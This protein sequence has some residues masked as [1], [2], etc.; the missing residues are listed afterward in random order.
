MAVYQAAGELVELA[1][2][3]AADLL[4]ASVATS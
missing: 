1:K 4:E 3:R 2:Q